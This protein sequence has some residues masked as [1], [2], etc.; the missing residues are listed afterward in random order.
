MN[1]KSNPTIFKIYKESRVCKEIPRG[2]LGNFS[3]K[4]RNFVSYNSISIRFFATP[5]KYSRVF[6]VESLQSCM[7]QEGQRYFFSIPMNFFSRL[8]QFVLRI[9]ESFLRISGI[10]LQLATLVQNNSNS[11]SD[12]EQHCY[13]QPWKFPENLKEILS[14]GSIFESFFKFQQYFSAIKLHLRLR[15]LEETPFLK[16]PLDFN[17]RTV[18]NQR[19]RVV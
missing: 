9:Y 2:Y 16:L 11:S 7:N 5:E 13:I 10:L 1:F 6:R 8:N 3:K 14:K 19:E 12:F 4:L 18:I 17:M 15:T